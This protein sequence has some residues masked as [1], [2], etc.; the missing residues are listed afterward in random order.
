M[1]SKA[2][3]IL[4]LISSIITFFFAAFALLVL[5]LMIFSPSSIENFPTKGNLPTIITII[6][7]FIFVFILVLGMF[8]LWASKLMKNPKTTTKGGIIALVCGILSLGDILAIVGGIL[9][10]AQGKE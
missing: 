3:P 2:G 7:F 5:I 4:L 8:K 6:Y 9:G 10:I 1:E